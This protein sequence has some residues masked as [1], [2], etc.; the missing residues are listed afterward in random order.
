MSS[1]PIKY[2]PKTNYSYSTY[3]ETINCCTSNDYL[4]GKQGKIGNTGPTGAWGYDGSTGVQGKTGPKGV[5]CT[6]ITG[7]V[8]PSAT[9][10]ISSL[11][12]SNITD[13]VTIEK[14]DS[15]N[16]NIDLIQI[17]PEDQTITVSGADLK[18]I[19]DAMKGG[20]FDPN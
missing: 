2:L 17:F 1:F 6:G 14:K 20:I 16:F 9:L 8:G 12:N 7:P 15:L 19:L 4:F 3:L 13:L 10:D 11:Y 5:G 18:K